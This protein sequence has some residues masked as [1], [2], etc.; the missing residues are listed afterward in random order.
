LSKPRRRAF[1]YGIVL[2]VIAI[3][4]EFG[5]ILVNEGSAELRS[6]NILFNVLGFA[7]APIIPI[8][9][10]AIFDTKILQM[11]KLFFLPSILNIVVVLL[12]PL[13]GLIFYVNV[14]N[15]Y[16]RG[17]FF[18]L[19]VLVYIINIIFMVISIWYTGQKYLYPI[20]WKIV[21][22]SFFTVIG[23]CVQLLFPSIYSSWHCVT[24]SLF[25]LYILLS[26]F[27]GRFD[28]LTK[29]Y[30]RS[31]FEKTTKQLTGKKI[32]SV[33]I[34]DINNFKEI[35]DT[36]GHEYGDIVLREIASIIRD[37]FDDNCSCYRIGGDEFCI[38]CRYANREKLEHQFKSIT[39]SLTKKRKEN[40]HFPTISYGY[41]IF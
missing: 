36:Y 24:L 18:F 31:A 14:N 34:I 6:F 10:I 1:S 12:S 28:T 22:L 5:T 11:N 21:S 13:F 26:E 2:T 41:S 33:I 23:T 39:N 37:S 32:F 40:R 27:E 17:S 20:K 4:S 3:I 38:I 29:L 7:L 15:H 30:N 19:F 35:N 16:E 25:L 8:V 9:L